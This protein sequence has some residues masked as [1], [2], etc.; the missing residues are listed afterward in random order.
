MGVDSKPHTQIQFV[1]WRRVYLEMKTGICFVDACAEIT[2]LLLER[3]HLLNITDDELMKPSNSWH[4]R[5]QAF[6]FDIGIEVFSPFFL[7]SLLSF[8]PYAIMIPPCRPAAVS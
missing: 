3:T 4:F 2:D 5:L 7:F 6:E 1:I 8:V